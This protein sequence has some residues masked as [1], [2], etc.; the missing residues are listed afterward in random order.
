MFDHGVEILRRRT[1][2]D[3]EPLALTLGGLGLFR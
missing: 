2:I 1:A 3:R